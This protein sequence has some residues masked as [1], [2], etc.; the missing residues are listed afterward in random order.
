MLII[1]SGLLLFPNPANTTISV[2]LENTVLNPTLKIT[3]ILGQVVY[4]QT[5][6]GM[7]KAFGKINISNLDNGVYVISISNDKYRSVSKFVKQ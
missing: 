2:V 6:E 1:D 5:L 4:N 3:N 7:Q